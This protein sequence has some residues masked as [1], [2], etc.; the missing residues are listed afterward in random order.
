MTFFALCTKRLVNRIHART[1]KESQMV[2]KGRIK[3]VRP[4]DPIS[5]QRLLTNNLIAGFHANAA[6]QPGLPI[7]S[8]SKF[9]HRIEFSWFWNLKGLGRTLPDTDVAIC[10]IFLLGE[11]LASPAGLRTTP[12]V[13]YD[14]PVMFR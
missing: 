5:E 9:V 7:G 11:V 1:L 4:E 6:C 14:R 3:W 12:S 10:V 13:F 8:T 2:T